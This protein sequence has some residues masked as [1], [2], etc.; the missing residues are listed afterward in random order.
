MNWVWNEK[1]MSNPQDAKEFFHP[2][3][4]EHPA[5]PWMNRLFERFDKEYR[6]TLDNAKVGNILVC[7]ARKV[8]I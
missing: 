8:E 7:H 3:P 2:I 1:P 5:A 6:M 4:W